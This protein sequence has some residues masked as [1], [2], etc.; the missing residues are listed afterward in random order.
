M[1]TPSSSVVMANARMMPVRLPAA[2][3]MSKLDSLVVPSTSTLNTR[4]PA[5]DVSLSWLVK[6]SRTVTFLPAAIGK[7]Q[8]CSPQRSVAKMSAGVVD[9]TVA[10]RWTVPPQL[11]VLPPLTRPASVVQLRPPSA[12][13]SAGPAA[14]TR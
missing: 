6:E 14:F 12:A 5:F 3:T 7:F 11:V 10:S 8:S 9:G 4:W 13:S 2:A 1:S